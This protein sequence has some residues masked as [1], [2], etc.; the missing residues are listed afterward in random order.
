MK[1]NK[2]SSKERN[3]E[4]RKETGEVGRKGERTKGSKS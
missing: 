4:A 3:K 1:E 2:G